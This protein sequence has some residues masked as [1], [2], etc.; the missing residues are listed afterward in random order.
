[1][2]AF[3]RRAFR[4]PLTDEEV[5]GFVGLSAFAVEANDFYVG[6]DL[7]LRA[8]LQDPQFLYRVEIGNRGRRA[9]P[10]ST[11]LG[12]YEIGDPALVLPLGLDAVRRLLDLAAGGRAAQR[13]RAAAPPRPSCSPTRAARARQALPRA[14][15][16]YH[17]LPLTADMA[18]AL[19]AETDALIDRVVFER[20]GDYFDLFT[21]ARRSS[22]TRWRRT[23]AS[24]RPG[25]ASGAWVPYGA[26]PRRGILSHGT[27]LAAGAK[28]DDTSPTLRGMFMRK[29]LLCQDH[30][31]AA[32]DVD[33]DEPP[34]AT[35]APARST[36]TPR[37]GGRL[38]RLPQPDRPGW[39]RPREL[40][41]RRRLPHH[42]QRQPECAIS[43]D[44]EVAGRRAHSTG[45]PSWRI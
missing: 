26:S 41:S 22:T 13:R 6:V 10:A 20:R 34:P 42:R 3:G 32:A 30:P 28:F 36:A 24:R 18:A 45:P 17:Q 25:S 43:G 15:A 11:R 2:R 19:R 35:G 33:V 12:D 9:S 16:G 4:R 1:M 44:G 5:S 8:L 39:L 38:R 21:R 37:T 27:L 40:R 23:T 14:L 29:R 31:A 7:V